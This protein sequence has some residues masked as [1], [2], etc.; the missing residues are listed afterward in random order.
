MAGKT[1]SE[2]GRDI[3]VH[4][5]NVMRWVK[6]KYLEEQRLLKLLMLSLLIYL[7]KV[8]TDQIAQLLSLPPTLV[9]YWIKSYKD[10]PIKNLPT[11][12][13]DS[14]EFDIADASNQFVHISL[15]E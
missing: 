7:E 9:R 3:G 14:Y 8:Q 13:G 5:A 2:F 4:R 1:Y 12:M 15:T 10:I 6:A 11:L